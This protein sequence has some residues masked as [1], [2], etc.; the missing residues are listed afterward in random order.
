MTL[1]NGQASLPLVVAGPAKNRE[2]AGSERREL[3]GRTS[4]VQTRGQTLREEGFSLTAV[5]RLAASLTAWKARP[6][7]GH[8]T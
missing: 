7:P 4:V 6:H 5:T 1:R 2:N 8:S 3:T